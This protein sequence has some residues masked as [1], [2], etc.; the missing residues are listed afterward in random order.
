MPESPGDILSRLCQDAA[1]LVLVAPYIKV[2][3]LARILAAIEPSASLTCITRWKAQDILI[4]ASDVQCRTTIKEYGGTFR[5]HSSLHAKYYR[6]DDVVLVGS[7]NLTNTALGWST[8]PNLEILCT[9]GPDFDVGAFEQYLFKNSREVSDADFAYWQAIACV[10]LKGGS[11]AFTENMRV[12]TWRPAT[13]DPKNL[14]MA[15]Q[16]EINQIA[17]LDEQGAAQRDIDI[18]KLPP[19]LTGTQIRDWALGYLLAAPFTDSV[20]Q[21]RNI[22][23]VIA[24]QI[25][26]K[27]YGL[28]VTE[29]R[30]SMEAVQNWLTFLALG[31]S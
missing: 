17:S 2:D 4:G 18:L 21:H 9:P 7:A 12:Q 23:P 16:G 24:T 29:A 11:A 20:I 15:Y 27:T 30:R 13:R 28:D 3:A 10:D 6:I 8:N 1:N 25:L 31:I 5:L 14:I 19:A 22:D 26:S